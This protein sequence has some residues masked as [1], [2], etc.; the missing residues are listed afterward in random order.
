[1]F[2]ARAR[3]LEGLKVATPQQMR[4]LQRWTHIEWLGGGC[5]MCS[6][7][8]RPQWPLLRLAYGPGAGLVLVL[9]VSAACGRALA[10]PQGPERALRPTML[11][12]KA[13]GGGSISIMRLLGGRG[14]TATRDPAGPSAAVRSGSW[15]WIVAAESKS[16]SGLTKLQKVALAVSF[17]FFTSLSLTF[18]NKAIFNRFAY[19]LLVF[20][21]S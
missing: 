4:P 11:G 13:H 14:R 18:A 6:S 17:Y 7:S 21:F 20:P 9:F 3:V 1:M 12:A 8:S 10:L 5:G 15:D 2:I 16:K 19:P